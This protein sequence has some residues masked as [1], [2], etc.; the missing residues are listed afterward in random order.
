MEMASTLELKDTDRLNIL[1]NKTKSICCL[2]ETHLTN[3]DTH[4][5]KVKDW[6]KIFHVNR[7]ERAG[8]AILMSEKINFNTK[9]VERYKE[10]NYIMIK[11][12]IQQE[13]VTIIKIY[14][15]KNRAMGYLK[16][17]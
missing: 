7:K 5:L 1:K 15:P 3:K 11:G 10:G 9:S 2:Q 12:L 14:A 6:K 17:T 8:V 16:G 4:R 13:V